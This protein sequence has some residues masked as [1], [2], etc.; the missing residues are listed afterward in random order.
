MY[1]S[2]GNARKDHIITF[3]ANGLC[4]SEQAKSTTSSIQIDVVV[5]AFKKTYTFVLEIG[6]NDALAYVV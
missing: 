5:F 3:Y 2:P 6:E 1:H 4:V